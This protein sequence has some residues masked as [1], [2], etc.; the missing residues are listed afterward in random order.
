MGSAVAEILAKNFPVPMEFVGMND[1]FGE[2]GP[3]NA[4][5]EK[6]GMGVKDVKEAVKKS[7]KENNFI[8]DLFNLLNPEIK[9]FSSGRL[10]VNRDLR[11]WRSF[12]LSVNKAEAQPPNRYGPG[13]IT[14]AASWET[15][16]S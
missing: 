10:G 15:E 5:L 12:S 2:S 3:P 4:L 9:I 16:L 11:H 13:A 14:T 7:S 8:H 6:Y 1:V